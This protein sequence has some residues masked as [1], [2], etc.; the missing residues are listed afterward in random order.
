MAQPNKREEKDID[1]REGK[2]QGNPLENANPTAR[3]S[4]RPDANKGK[5]TED[6][7]LNKKAGSDYEEEEEEQE[8]TS[9]GA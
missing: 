8:D 4:Q 7:T 9:G 6:E 1:P 5:I 3:N 2:N